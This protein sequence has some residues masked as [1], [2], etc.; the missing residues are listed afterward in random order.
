MPTTKKDHI[1]NILRDVLKAGPSAGR[2]YLD[3]CAEMILS[4]SPEEIEIVKAIGVE[5]ISP[6]P[7]SMAEVEAKEQ[8]KKY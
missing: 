8:K 5:N 6:S 7:S 2:E 3:L 1:R 4:Y